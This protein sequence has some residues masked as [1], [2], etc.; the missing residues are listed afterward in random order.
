MQTV[1]IVEILPTKIWI[2]SGMWGERAVMM[3]HEGDEPF[4][5][6]VFN[7]NYRYTSNA[8][9]HRAAEELARSLGA[10]GEIEHKSRPWT[11][12]HPLKG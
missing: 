5:Y 11:D 4:E 12:T 6:A 3:Q 2:E 1:T 8:G 7:Y 10:V 9:T